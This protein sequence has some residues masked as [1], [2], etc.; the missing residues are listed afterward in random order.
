MNNNNP[1]MNNN[2]NQLMNNNNNPMNNNNNPMMMNNNINPM[3]NNNNPM[4]MNNNI[5]PMMNKNNNPMMMNNNPMM[6]NN[7]NNQKMNNIKNPMMINNNEMQDQLIEF[8]SMR[9]I[10]NLYEKRIKFLEEQ[11]KKKD[12]EIINLKNRLSS[13]F[14]FNQNMQPFNFNVMMMQ[15]M[16]NFM[17]RINFINQL[18]DS[19]K[20]MNNNSNNSIKNLTLNFSFN[21]NMKIQIMCKSNEKMKSVIQRFLSKFGNFGNNNFIYIFNAKKINENLTV[22]ESGLC[23]NGIIHVIDRKD[24][25]LIQNIPEISTSHKPMINLSFNLRNGENILII[26]EKDARI[27][28]AIIKFFNKAGI[29]ASESIYFVYNGVKI[30]HNDNRKIKELFK[31][32]DSI[33]VID[34]SKV[35]GA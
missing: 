3:M 9:N 8:N 26:I 24:K 16:M 18:N 34:I 4:M 32:N 15:Q 19:N 21:N 14:C 7:N 31:N 30:D 13:N 20:M 23:N 25:A 28:E 6:V 11:I 33:I 35:Y 12:S 22:E 1:M 29:V 10:I 5:N 17:N 2:N 27:S